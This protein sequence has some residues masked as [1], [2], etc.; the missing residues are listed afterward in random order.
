[1][2]I[3]NFTYRFIIILS[4]LHIGISL[5]SQ[6]EIKSEFIFHTVSRGETVMGYPKN[7]KLI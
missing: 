1:M 7:T 3:D 6:S 4:F 5:K 2:G